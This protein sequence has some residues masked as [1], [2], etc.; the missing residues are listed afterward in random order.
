MKNLIM[1]ALFALPVSAFAEMVTCKLVEGFN[2]KPVRK[3]FNISKAAMGDKP[4][5]FKQS[6]GFRIEGGATTNEMDG[7]RKYVV[8]AWTSFWVNG[9]RQILNLITAN[10]KELPV[11]L[12]FS[13]NISRP[14]SEDVSKTAS[15][16]CD[17][18]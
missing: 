7:T 10:G 9:K 17:Y 5:K 15:I 16:E 14:E 1:I 4:L 11:R 13:T 18:R 6:N 8:Y 12:S 3:T 2:T